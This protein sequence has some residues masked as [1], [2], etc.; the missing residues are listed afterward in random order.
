MLSPERYVTLF[1]G[2]CAATARS[3]ELGNHTGG[4]LG[5]SGPGGGGGTTEPPGASTCAEPPPVSTP[6]SACPPIKITDW[7]EGFSGSTRSLFLRSTMLFSAR[8]NA[9]AS[10][11]STS[12]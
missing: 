3:G 6:T 11:P 10:P 2:N 12:G 1:G 5:R 8:F 7:L 4:R 9:S